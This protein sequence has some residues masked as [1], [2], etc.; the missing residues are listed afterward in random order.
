M[1]LLPFLC[2]LAATLMVTIIDWLQV[3]N[4][5][6]RPARPN[7]A[8][9]ILAGNPHLLTALALIVLAVQPLVQSIRDNWLRAQPT[10]RVLAT[11]WVGQSA[12]DGTRIWLEDQTLILPSR[13]RVQG[14]PLVTTHELDWYRENGFRFLVVNEDVARDDGAQLTQFG[15]PAARFEPVGRHGP[16]L[17][18]Y[19]TGFGDPTRDQRTPSGATL[20][21]GAI[22]LDGYRHPSE[23]RPGTTLPLA[24]YWRATRSLPA[25]YTVY[26]HLLDAAGN[27]A[28]QRDLPPLDGSLPTSRWKPD[29]LIRD[30]QDLA[31]PPELAPGTYRLVV[32]MYDPVTFAAINDAG[33]IDLGEVIIR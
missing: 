21:A 10:T 1:P 12:A 31:L 22:V 30:D 19:D 29:Q 26:V 25:D 28:A 6:S 15:T 20:G 17:A 27:K 5:A 18:I 8:L 11:E 23:A 14:G 32:G 9:G 33:P 16:V 3:R 7:R 2:L 24:L 13:L 4:V